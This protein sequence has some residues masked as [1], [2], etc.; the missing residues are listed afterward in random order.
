MN[1]KFLATAITALV[2]SHG[3]ALAEGD[4]KKGKAVF[5][6]CVVCHY[7]DKEKNKIGPHLVGII[8][9]KAGVAEKF[10]YSKAMLAKA[11]EGLVWDEANISAYLE[12]PRKFI[13]KNKMAFAGLRKPTDR[14]NVIAY[15][16]EAAK[17]KD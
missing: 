10:K 8:G 15:L 12:K 16:K 9:R 5:K 6:R 13:P 4:A 3:A 2:V 7:I 1:Q 11:S 17:K 14:A